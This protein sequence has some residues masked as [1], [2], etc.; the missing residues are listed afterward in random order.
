M[1]YVDIIKSLSSGQLKIHYILYR[2]LNRFLLVD[3]TKKDLNPGQE[4]ELHKLQLFIPHKGIVEQVQN[5]DLGA[6]LHGLHAKNLIG[7]FQSNGHKLE[8][9]KVVPY[10]EFSPT[11]LGIQL[12]AIANNRFP[13]WRNF[14]TSDFGD[15]PDVILPKYYGSSI[16]SILE[17]AGL[18]NKSDPSTLI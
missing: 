11:T 6:I 1:F 15:F 14:S 12:F 4:S 7:N 5:E 3:T 18:K 10:I 16:D 13:Q 17:Q 2:A 9:D 8:N